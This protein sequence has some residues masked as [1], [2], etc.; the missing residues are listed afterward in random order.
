MTD[1]W[2]PEAEW[3]Q[4]VRSVPIVSV[5]LVVVH[6]GGIVLG[7]RTNEPAKGTWFVPGGRVHKDERFATAVHRVAEMELGVDVEI[8]RRIGTYQHFYDVSDVAGASKHYVAVGF[9]V[10]P[11][12]TDFDPDGQHNSLQTFDT[13]PPETH[14]Y[15]RAYLRDSGVI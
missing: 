9:V 5:D 11:Q 13:V 15:T 4:V 7:R 6:D 14:E 12:S 3:E 8:E 1:E 2:L 10:S